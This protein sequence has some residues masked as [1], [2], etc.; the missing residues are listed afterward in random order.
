MD[1]KNMEYLDTKNL[2][3]LNNRFVVV[4]RQN[5]EVYYL[6]YIGLLN[7]NA[8]YLKEGFFK[9]AK[10]AYLFSSHHDAQKQCDKLNLKS[11]GD[12]FEVEKASNHFASNFS[13]NF[14]TS[15]SHKLELINKPVSFEELEKVEYN[16]VC[17][18]ISEEFIASL[19]REL[20]ERDNYLKTKLN[21]LTTKYH[22]KIKEINYNYDCKKQS[23][24]LRLSHGYETE[25]SYYNEMTKAEKEYKE[26]IKII[27]ESYKIQKENYEKRIKDV[28]NIIE[29]V[30]NGTVQKLIAECK[31]EID[32]KLETLYWV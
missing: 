7:P 9:D 29:S 3:N 21:E 2:I 28:L 19:L 12:L 13:L 18:N 8:P 11:E 30:K 31:T 23:L 4:K 26:K 24:K 6:G 10:E 15:F 20:Q 25:S 5:N 1:L 32:N 14:E 17:N 16:K 27:E 22:K